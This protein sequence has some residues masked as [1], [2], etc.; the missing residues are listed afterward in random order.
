MAT[1][2]YADAKSILPDDILAAILTL[3]K[4]ASGQ[5]RLAFRG[6]DSELQRVFRKLVREYHHPLM[7]QFV[8]SKGGPEPYSPILN[9]SISRL[10]L[11][12]LVGR[13]NPDYEML[14][15]RPSAERY[16]HDELEQRFTRAEIRNLKQV[17]RRLWQLVRK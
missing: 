4:E 8:F 13:E 16:F 5:E 1:A 9:E 11:S 2:V 15:L 3:A 6:H 14:F 12:G 17:G 7:E 10:Q